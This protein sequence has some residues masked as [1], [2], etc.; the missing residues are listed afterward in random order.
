ME[1]RGT[2]PS[3]VYWLR[4]SKGQWSSASISDVRCV[5]PPLGII[6]LQERRKSAIRVEII[7]VQDGKNCCIGNE[8]SDILYY[9]PGK[10]H[11]MRH[12]L[13]LL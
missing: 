3:P 5:V 1:G 7:I 10:A 2:I 11:S 12:V 13:I 4:K 9:V 8:D 6:S